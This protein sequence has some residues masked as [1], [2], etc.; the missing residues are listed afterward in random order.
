MKSTL[1]WVNIQVFSLVELP[2]PF[3]DGMCYCSILHSYCYYLLF[4]RKYL[5][6]FYCYYL[7]FWRKYLHFLY[8][9]SI[10]RKQ[11]HWTT[12]EV[13][14]AFKILNYISC[15]F[16]LIP[17]QFSSEQIKAGTNKK[18]NSIKIYT[19]CQTKYK[20][21]DYSEN[22]GVLNGVL[23][24]HRSSFYLRRFFLILAPIFS[25]TCA[26]FLQVNFSYYLSS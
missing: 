8:L 18:S 13:K 14:K 2:N 22:I 24:L 7:F 25:F 17:H 9:I 5:H 20:F 11:M 1:I 21:N 15:E 3:C 10:C 19:L 4:W 26:D 16:T 12:V 6:C 23:H